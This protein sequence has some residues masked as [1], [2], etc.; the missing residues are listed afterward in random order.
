M[1]SSQ[2]KHLAYKNAPYTADYCRNYLSR[3]FSFSISRLS[4]TFRLENNTEHQRTNLVMFFFMKYQIFVPK[5][6]NILAIIRLG[7][8]SKIVRWA[9]AHHPCFGKSSS[10]ISTQGIPKH[11]MGTYNFHN[12]RF[13][14][15]K[16]ER[17]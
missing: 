3:R 10:Q 6:P 16:N 8:P 11:E 5:T 13:Y 12:S 15:L 14:V 7:P 1:I 2:F 17:W 4:I 9:I